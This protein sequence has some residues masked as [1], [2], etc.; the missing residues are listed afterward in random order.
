[1]SWNSSTTKLMTFDKDKLEAR[2]IEDKK[3]FVPQTG[4]K[5]MDDHFGLRPGC[6]HTLMGSTGAGKSTL[7]QSLLMTWGKKIEVLVYLTEENEDRFEKKIFE[8]NKN[9]EFLSPNVHL[10]HEKQILISQ[11]CEN[12]RAMLQEIE[13]AIVESSAKILVID[14]LTTS[15]F[16]EGKISAAIP[17]LSGFRNLAEHYKI[18][19]FIVVHTR[20]GVSEMSKGLMEPDDV[21]GSANISNTSDYFYTFYRVGQTTGTGQKVWGSFIFVNKTRDHDTQGNM[22][23]LNY[24]FSNKTYHSDKQVSFDLFKKFMKDKDRL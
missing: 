23:T 7:M 1:M 6:I 14:N 19:I 11:P 17:I 10:M 21:R 20:K 15:A 3:F 22:Y 13:K 8:K 5:F 9:S 24:D 16:Y 18:A 2:L 12:Y 4:L